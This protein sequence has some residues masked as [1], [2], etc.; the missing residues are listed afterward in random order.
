[1]GNF[2]VN[3]TEVLRIQFLTTLLSIL[4]VSSSFAFY[5]D[6]ESKGGSNGFLR[7]SDY[8]FLTS[9]NNENNK[10]T[11]V[12]H[13]VEYLPAD[14]SVDYRRLY[15]QYDTNEQNRNQQQVVED[16]LD[17]TN[18]RR[19]NVY[20]PNRELNEDTDSKSRYYGNSRYDKQPFVE[21]DT[22]YSSYQQAWRMLGFMI[23][24]DADTSYSYN[25]RKNN[26][27]SQDNGDYMTG[28]GCQRYVVWAAVCIDL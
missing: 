24:C 6:E 25:N 28:Q 16:D 1:M 9:T 12:S 10:W 23:D 3:K 19:S 8:P 21:G 5:G 26:H 18:T 15:G 13:T 22:E 27:N 2:K 11:S 14:E 4:I 7:K 17:E 20:Y